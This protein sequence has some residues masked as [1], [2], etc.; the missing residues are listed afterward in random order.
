VN[1]SELLTWLCKNYEEHVQCWQAPD[2]TLM[3]CIK[4]LGMAPVGIRVTDDSVIIS[5]R[6][7][8]LKFLAKD[9]ERKLTAADK[10]LLLRTCLPVAV[11]LRNG[12]LVFEGW[13]DD[14]LT[15][16]ILSWS[17]WPQSNS[18]TNQRAT[19]SKRSDGEEV[20]H[21]RT[22]DKQNGI[23]QTPQ[24][25][26]VSLVHWAVRSASDRV[27]DIGA[28]TGVFLVEA[29]RRL[30]G[31]GA[32]LA[33]AP[34]QLY[35]VERD[36]ALFAQLQDRF[37]AMT[38]SS[39]PNVQ[40]GSLFESRFPLV[41]AVIGNPPYVR[42]WWLDNLDALH[43]ALPLEAKM[44]NL[45]RL[46][47]LACYFV[48][49]AAQFLKPRGR[50]ALVLT[51]A[52][53]DMDYGIEFKRYLLRYFE[54]RALA[55][56]RSR[57]FDG[58][59]VRPVLL[60][61]EKATS[62]KPARSNVAFVSL[63]G[64]CPAVNLLPTRLRRSAQFVANGTM[65]LRRIRQ[66]KLIPEDSWSIYL[67]APPAYF[68]LAQHPLM[69]P[70]SSLAETRI[71]FQT[72]A[73]FFYVVRY[74]NAEALRL[75]RQ[76]LCPYVT[77][78]RDVDGPV[79][80]DQSP[81]TH[82]LVCCDREKAELRGTRLLDY[83]T[84]WESQPLKPRGAPESVVGVHNLPRVRRARRQ[85]WYN[86]VAEVRRRG[87]FPIL[88]PRRLYKR[89]CAVWNRARRIANEDFI[90][91]HP[92]AGVDLE[93]L[94]AVLNS[95]VCELALRVHGHIYGGGVCNLNPG[96]IG[97]VP[98]LNIRVLSP[99]GVNAL[100]SAYRQFISSGGSD[101]EV[102]DRA[103]CDL[104]NVSD[105]FSSAVCHGIAELKDLSVSVQRDFA[106]TSSTP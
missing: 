92:K 36:P 42:R 7:T 73:K 70:L 59:L 56:F 33:Q 63:R 104:L 97:K 101:R 72:F 87:A 78:L 48:M 46:T 32:K 67:H 106:L 37:R 24:S 61:A 90:E 47:D 44:F 3:A 88:L 50:L 22:H 68:V 94:L 80:E 20:G 19:G 102:I 93:T 84:H 34:A 43:D 17:Q 41:D 91:V 2:G 79:I 57:V 13:F 85:P 54:L 40:L 27:L 35:G 49:Y 21:V 5:D 69:A 82:Y 103:L 98:V 64:S 100:K 66:D 77:S 75:E 74:E 81:I 8:T 1:T 55:G 76:F 16:I 86:V 28:G 15:G 52:W 65:T 9:I 39:L 25:I 58:V 53:L 45:K 18:I 60:L 38:G 31:L 11:R 71:G 95:S 26:A 12:E 30:V 83:I 14:I 105:D 4:T 51:D 99:A 10:R 6:G 96:D 23:V 29:Y 62:E 89:F